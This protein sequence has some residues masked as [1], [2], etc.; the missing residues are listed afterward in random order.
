[1]KSGVKCY[2]ISCL[3]RC[4]VLGFELSVPLPEGRWFES[5]PRYQSD[6]EG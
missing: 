4:F 3:L 1:M 6:K 5:N 2:V